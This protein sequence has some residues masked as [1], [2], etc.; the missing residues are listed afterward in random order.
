M[1]ILTIHLSLIY[2]DIGILYKAI[3]VIYNIEWKSG[4]RRDH[5]L[6]SEQRKEI[7]PENPHRPFTEPQLIID[8]LK[9]PD[10]EA[11]LLRSY[12]KGV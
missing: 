4:Y 8:T 3:E 7:M 11:L 9:V 5:Q 6:Y 1:V 2:N 12:G 10:G